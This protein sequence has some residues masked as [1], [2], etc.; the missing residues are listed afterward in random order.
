MLLGKLL[1]IPRFA[2][3]MMNHRYRHRCHRPQRKPRIVK[4]AVEEKRTAVTRTVGKNESE[5][6]TENTTNAAAPAGNIILPVMILP[7]PKARIPW[8]NLLHLAPRIPTALEIPILLVRNRNENH[9]LYQRH[10]MRKAKPT[11]AVQAMGTRLRPWNE[12]G[13]NGRSDDMIKTAINER[14]S[15]VTENI[16]S[17]PK[18]NLQVSY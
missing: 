10:G 15:T 1:R 11:E 13:E 12:G 14:G 6:T 4:G 18:P 8:G 17:A 3:P 9:H 7:S 5:R 16:T 2:E